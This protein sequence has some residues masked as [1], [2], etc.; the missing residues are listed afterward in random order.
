MNAALE[1]LLAAARAGGRTLEVRVPG[2]DLA[3][4][5]ASLPSE[6]M[7]FW[8]PPGGPITLGLGAAMLLR[9][10]GEQ[11]FAMLRDGATELPAWA[12]LYCG[13]AFTPGGGGRFGDAL[14]ILPR[15][16]VP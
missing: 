15:F 14:A 12:E 9:G 7:V 10:R 16:H 4:L 1:Q 11:R 5:S 3:A 13:F 2:L 8:A 6:P